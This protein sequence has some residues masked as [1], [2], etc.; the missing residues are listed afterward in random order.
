MKNIIED[1]S[2]SENFFKM[3][4]DAR[5]N[6]LKAGSKY[7]TSQQWEIRRGIQAGLLRDEQVSIPKGAYDDLKYKIKIVIV[8]EEI[9]VASKLTTL[10]TVLQ[11][12][13]SNPT[14]LQD[15]RIRRVFYKMLDM[16][17]INPKELGLDDVQAELSEVAEGV[18]AQRGGSIATPQVSNQPILMPTTTT[19]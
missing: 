14:I 7:L 2:A 9:D 10:Q 13:G 3:T 15:K 17:G 11:I 5:M 8:G 16:A 4:L 12:I 1:D 6:K 19:A 18:R